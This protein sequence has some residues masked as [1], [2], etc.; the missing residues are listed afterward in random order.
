MGRNRRVSSMSSGSS[1]AVD[2]LGWVEAEPG[3]GIPDCPGAYAC[4]EEPGVP[5]GAG[6]VGV[7]KEG[8]GRP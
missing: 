8:E 3:P 5:Y 4:G 1:R 7:E 2:A 6:S